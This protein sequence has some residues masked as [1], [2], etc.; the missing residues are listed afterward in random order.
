MSLII[1][2][3]SVVSPTNSSQFSKRFVQKISLKT[4]IISV[5]KR[6]IPIPKYTLAVRSRTL[7]ASGG[8]TRYIP[9]PHSGGVRVQRTPSRSSSSSR[10]RASSKS[11]CSVSRAAGYT[12]RVTLANTT[13]DALLSLVAAV[14]FMITRL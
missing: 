14:F 10:R 7:A 11:Q 6:V 9:P 8:G 4:L 2:Q 13:D 12:A 5:Q 1:D 3:A